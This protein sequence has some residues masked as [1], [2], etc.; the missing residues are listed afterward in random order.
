MAGCCSCQETQAKSRKF[1]N[2]L[3]I[4]LFLNFTMFIVE[5]TGGAHT[6]STSLWAD[7]LDFAGDSFNYLISIFVLGL[8]L[9]WRAIAALLKGLMML[10]F[11]FIVLGKV[12]WSYIHGV[13][14]EAITMGII[15]T[16]ALIANI[17]TALIL[18]A[19]LDGEANMKSV[20]LCSR[21][22]AIGN[23]AVVL[24]AVGVFGTQQ[25]WPDLIVALI[26]ILLGLSSS[27]TIIRTSWK[28][29]IQAKL[30]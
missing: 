26:M 8:G 28:E 16:L 20:W 12:V 21:N 30:G 23:V 19:F 18:Y 15:G 22:D 24:A 9:Y 13:P 2:A 7:A 17:L 11:A 4:A 3:W 25:V 29:R 10:V 1:R 5:V 27:L 6:G 14:P